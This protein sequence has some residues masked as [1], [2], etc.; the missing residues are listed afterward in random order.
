MTQDMAQEQHIAAIKQRVGVKEFIILIAALMATNAVAI[1]IMLP[2][3]D[4]IK[5]SLGVVGEN[6]HHYIIFCYLLGFGITQL[7]VGPLSDRLG[8]RVPL[9]IGLIFY[10]IASFA[11]AF[12][13]SFIGLLILRAI[14]GIGAAA[15]R[16]LCVSVVRDLYGGRQMAEVMSIVMMVFMVV[17]IIAPA[18]GQGILM[19]GPWQLI[20]FVMAAVGII[21]AVWVWKRLP[22]TLFAPRPLTFSAITQGFKTVLSNKISFCYNLAF[23]VIL[24]ALFGALNTA[25]QIYDGIYGLGKWF[26]AAFAAVA[27]FQALAAFL[28]SR[29]VGRFGMRRISHFLLLAFVAASFVLFLWAWLT[30]THVPFI[31]YMLLFTV[32]MF[33]FGAIGAN[34]NSL[35]MEPLGA[36]AGTASSVFGFMQTLIGAGGGLLISHFFHAT[37]TPIAAG[38]FIVGILALILVLIAEDGKLFRTVSA[39]PSKAKMKTIK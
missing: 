16:V 1:D 36:V 4:D 13:P 8:R 17:P 23:S 12:A 38:F 7:F 35:A 11:C 18:T 26:P 3:F 24:S 21:M 2:A 10:A 5:A 29:F 33:A 14:Q 20:F 34:F 9:I 30:P 15:T 31:P 22:E 27:T 32:I 37:I 28:N 25:Q 6:A 39:D 19:L